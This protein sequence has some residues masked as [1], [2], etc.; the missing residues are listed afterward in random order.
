MSYLER[1]AIVEHYIEEVITYP[2]RYLRGLEWIPDKK[3]YFSICKLLKNDPTL[4]SSFVEYCLYQGEK[5]DHNSRI[6]VIF[7]NFVKKCFNRSNSVNN[8][9]TLDIR[10]VLENEYKP[11][12]YNYHIEPRY[13]ACRAIVPKSPIV[14]DLVT[15]KELEEFQNKISKEIKEKVKDELKDINSR[16]DKMEAK[17]DS[18]IAIFNEKPAILP[19]VAANSPAVVIS[20]PADSIPDIDSFMKGLNDTIKRALQ[21]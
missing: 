21:N 4:K 18:F 12:H 15:K 14:D 17:L 10:K 6:D 3:L 20:P 1:R 8:F 9:D 19:P 16:F 11:Y 2:D 5:L 13:H 7:Y